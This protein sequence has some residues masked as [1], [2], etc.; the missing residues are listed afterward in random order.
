MD[1]HLTFC[2]CIKLTSP[3]VP[4]LVYTH[5][6]GSLHSYNTHKHTIWVW[7]FPLSSFPLVLPQG[8]DQLKEGTFESS[9][10]PKV[11][12]G[13]CIHLLVSH[14]ESILQRW[15]SFL[16]YLKN[17]KLLP[18]VHVNEYQDL[19]PPAAVLKYL[20]GH[21]NKAAIVRL[22]I[23]I[24]MILLYVYVISLEKWPPGHVISCR[25]VLVRR[26]T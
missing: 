15:R 1:L 8:K 16:F 19:L 11:T 5:T 17:K 14:V 24:Y 18:A 7:V 26:Y 22:H 20:S 3:C 2:L 12:A 10:Q 6:W 4:F 21:Q 25:Q 23:G 13:F 9:L